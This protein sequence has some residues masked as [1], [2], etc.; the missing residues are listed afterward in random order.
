MF[1]TADPTVSSIMTAFDDVDSIFHPPEKTRTYR[2]FSRHHHQV[3]IPA[4]SHA[5]PVVN[6]VRR[7]DQQGISDIPDNTPVSTAYR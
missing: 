7:P 1:I 5:H 2:C 3:E 6:P 4:G